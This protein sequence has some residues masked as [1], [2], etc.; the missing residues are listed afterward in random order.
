MKTRPMI[1]DG[2]E[3][4]MRQ[5]AIEIRSKR[6][7]A[8]LETFIWKNGK[9]IAMEGYNDDLVMSLCIALWVRDT[10]LRLRQ[11][12]TELTRLA[13]SGITSTQKDKT[14]V[15]KATQQQTGFNSWKMNT[16]RQGFGKNNQEDLR[17][18]IS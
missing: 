17:W 10:A 14:P 3:H 4:Y 8:E 15:Y 16:G 2:M 13:V 11:E 1:I 12:G 5:M 6:T 7:L 9:P 18:L